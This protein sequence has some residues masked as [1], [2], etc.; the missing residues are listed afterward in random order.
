[1]KIQEKLKEVQEYF[2]AKLLSGEF[3]IISVRE[4]VAVVV[5]E[6]CIF[7]VWIANSCLSRGLYESAENAVLFE[8]EQDEKAQLDGVITPLVSEYRILE[9]RSISDIEKAEMINKLKQEIAELEGRSE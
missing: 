5:I 6:G 8:L 4:C 3:E 9:R 2:K 7:S 1:M